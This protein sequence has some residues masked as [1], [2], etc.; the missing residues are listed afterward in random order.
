MKCSTR[1]RHPISGRRIRL[2][3]GSPREL[4]AYKHAIDRMR[5]E[6]RL[7]MSTAAEVEATMRRLRFGVVTLERAALSYIARSRLAQGTRDAVRSLLDGRL[8]PI[9][10]LPLEALDRPTVA[11]WIDGLVGAGLEES[12]VDNLWRR[13]RAIVGHAAERGWIDAPPWGMYKPKLRRRPRNQREAARTVAEFARLLYAARDLDIRAN[14]ED[15]DPGDREAMLACAGLLGLR[16]GELAGL[17]WSDWDPG[18][19]PAMRVAR[20]WEGRPI[21][22]NGTPTRL[23]TIAELVDILDAYRERLEAWELYAPEGPIFPWRK[24]RRGA[25][26]P[27]RSGEPLT[28]GNVRAAALAA[29]LPNVGAWSAHS[30]RD[31]FVTLESA[32]TGGDLARVG[33]RSRHASLAS[34]AR[35]LR[36]LS[37]NHPSAPAVLRLP[38]RSASAE[39]VPPHAAF[40]PKQETPRK[41][42][43]GG[44]ERPQRLPG[45]E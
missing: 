18:P 30:L 38:G 8:Q 39:G 33:A 36:Q 4:E 7:G 34:L 5:T 31:T 41:L 17:R 2:R 45:T 1:P 13:V 42:L 26:V 40:P 29:G 24:S 6:L 15:K 27:Y 43:G 9:A 20:Q 16:Q 3:A 11:R 37:R 44:K 12:T 19:P 32:M 35:Y 23:E 22:M 14:F 10:R 25:P 21:K 28:R